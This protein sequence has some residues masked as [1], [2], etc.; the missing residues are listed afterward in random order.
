MIK[1]VRPLPTTDL[2]NTV[3]NENSR[4]VSKIEAWLPRGEDLKTNNFPRRCRQGGG[5]EDTI[6]ECDIVAINISKR[7][8]N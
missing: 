3:K 6:I 8:R 7:T 1:N 5:F 4:L 2:I